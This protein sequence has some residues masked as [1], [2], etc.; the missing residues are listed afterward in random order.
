MGRDL[1]LIKYLLQVKAGWHVPRL[2]GLEVET[3]QSDL[4]LDFSLEPIAQKLNPPQLRVQGN[5]KVAS[6]TSNRKISQCF[7]PEEV[8]PSLPQDVVPPPG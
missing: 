5:G 7:P 8:P 4:E 6:N 1:N 3:M 2:E